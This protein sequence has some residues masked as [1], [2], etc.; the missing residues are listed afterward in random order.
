MSELSDLRIHDAAPVG[1]AADLV[2]RTATEVGVRAEDADALARTAVELVEQARAREWFGDHP[3]PVSLKL[4][5]AHSR[6]QLEVRDTRM[7]VPAEPL[8]PAVAGPVTV[9]RDFAGGNIVRCGMPLVADLSWLAD[10]TRIPPDAAVVDDSVAGSVVFRAATPEDA[11]GIIRLTYRCYGYSHP[12]MGDPDS[13]ARE[14][15]SGR[16]TSQIA[17]SG[18]EV[19]GHIALVGDGS[20]GLPELGRLIVDP[21][22]RGHHIA[23]H[24][25]ADLIPRG[26]EAGLAAAWGE[27][28]TNHPISQQVVSGI[29]GVAVGG[30]LDAI[31]PLTMAGMPDASHHRQ[32]LLPMI[33]PLSASSPSAAHLPEHYHAVYLDLTERLGLVRTVTDND[34]APD[35]HTQVRVTANPVAGSVR[36]EVLRIGADSAEVVLAALADADADHTTVRYLDIPL[37]DPAA[38]WGV[39]IA[40]TY[41]YSWAALLPDDRGAG[42]V[43]RMQY[44]GGATPDLSEARCATEHGREM[45]DFALADHRRVMRALAE[46][47]AAPEGGV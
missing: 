34:L 9:Q 22:F 42:D 26:R 38:P 30:L 13:V 45:L 16:M 47:A 35:G 37:E 23:E 39:R 19:T 32:T 8:T 15:A 12:L 6:L 40:E 21:R 44:I 28:V 36:V 31:P 14:L 33:V 7:P 10:E 1:A 41:G 25:V 20:D 4:S 29:G 2:K 46:A 43:V 27:A 3:D 24:L 11:K 18:S 5:I 17:V